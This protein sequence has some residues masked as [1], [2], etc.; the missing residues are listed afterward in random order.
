MHLI[1]NRLSRFGLALF[2]LLLSLSS[3]FTSPSSVRKSTE[4]TCLNLSL[5]SNV[6]SL[7]PGI[8]IDGASAVVIKMLFEG[9]VYRDAEGHIQP[10]LA[11][12]YTISQDRKTYTFYLKNS[13]WSNGLPV[14]AYDFEYAWKKVIG[15]HQESRSTAVHHF[16]IIKNVARY[17]REECSL[18]E[19]GVRAIDEKILEVELQNPVPYFLEAIAT[20]SFFPICKVVDE[21]NPNWALES[22]EGFVC[23]GPFRL[24]LHKFD[25]ELILEK[26][27]RFWDARDVR[28]EEVKICIVKD[29]MTSLH[30]F[31]KGEIDWI[32]RPL[33]KLPLDALDQLKKEK[34]LTILP[35]LGIYWYLFNTEKFPFHNK[36]IRLAF[37]YALHRKE[38]AEY[39]LQA[40]EKPAMGILPEPF[41]FQ[42]Q[43][44]FE[45]H[46]VE[47]ARELLAKGLKE[48]GIS[49]EEFPEITLSFNE[50]ETH[51]KV[52]S[53]IREQLY[54]GLGITICLR[55]LEWGVH[56][57]S[58]VHGD[59][60]LGGFAWHS[61]MRD[62]IYTFQSFLNKTDGINMSRW[63]HSGYQRLIARSEEEADPI[64][65]REILHQAEQVLMEELPIL[66][67]YFTTI[68]FAKSKRLA[69]EW[70]SELCLVDFR[71]AYFLE[72]ASY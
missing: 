18:D 51:R 29:S 41:G 65:R 24:D 47:K 67:I 69:G 26:N 3:C 43:P 60:A 66:P 19:V 35:C 30:L 5:S 2:F 57:S 59:F 72:Q 12:E 45:D 22:G 42:T 39:V 17:L 20:G 70:I 36:N 53:T 52:A 23:N 21:K 50:D 58:L 34:K 15:R 11:R 31:E 33:G 25:N 14:T 13:D 40:G 61:W 62:P 28:L 8:G 56:F 46:N 1:F 68:A 4:K 6:R 55:P 71:Y 37:A 54:K 44:Y 48:L 10:A 64:A 63:E 32:G 7:N 9:L 38:I 27:P 49:L 16:Y